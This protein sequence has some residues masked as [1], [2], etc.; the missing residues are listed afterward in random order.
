MY[1][2]ILISLILGSTFIGALISSLF[3]LRSATQSDSDKL[4]FSTIFGLSVVFYPISYTVGIVLIFY[5]QPLTQSEMWGIA[6]GTL[7]SLLV[8]IMPLGL[9]S[10]MLT[11][12]FA[13]LTNRRYVN[14]GGPTHGF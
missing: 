14:S 5:F 4:D 7:I 12:A 11:H 2:V 3:A 8:G 9:F 1:P 10:W 13:R 6:L